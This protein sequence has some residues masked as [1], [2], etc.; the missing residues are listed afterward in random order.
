M[1]QVKDTTGRMNELGSRGLPFLVI[2]DFE[3]KKPEVLIPEEIADRGILADIGGFCNHSDRPARPT[4][5]R[6]SARPV[7]RERY[8]EAFAKVMAHLEHG[9]TFLLNLTF[10]TPVETSLNLEDFF[11]H[12]Q[13]KYRLHYPGRFTVFSPEPFVHISGRTISTFPMKGTWDASVPG[14]EA[15]LLGDPKETAEHYTV[16]DLLRNDLGMVAKNIKV[17]R[18]RYIEHIRVREGTLLQTSSHITGELEPDW[19]SRIGD[20]L[21]RMLPA[22]S[23]SGAP[24]RRT[25]EII[26]EAEG[27]DRGY[28][29]GVFG[30]FDGRNFESAVMIRFVEQTAGGMVYRS[31]GGIHSLSDCDTEY[32]E[33]IQKVYVP[34]V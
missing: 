19:H 16:T 24:K 21:F 7:T 27:E 14:A 33:M 8:S 22:G 34:F 3:M 1:D 10:P 4:G 30:Y 23:V 25:M 32:E 11:V 2:A 13:E 28:Y 17:E 26:R 18:F 6:F 5:I 9:N 12:S 20:I 31:G 29:T 15:L